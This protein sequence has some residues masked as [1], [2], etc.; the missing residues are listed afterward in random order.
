[1]ADCTMLGSCPFYND[2]LV[3]MPAIAGSLKNR[4]CRDEFE[5][6]AR[7]RVSTALGKEM[8][9]GNLFP[10]EKSTADMLLQNHKQ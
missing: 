3:N 5:S 10:H 8:V 4:F 1:M 7:Y 6:C 2:N 9:P